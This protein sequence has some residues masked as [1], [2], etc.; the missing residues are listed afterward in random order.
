MMATLRLFVCVAVAGIASATATAA[1]PAVPAS[2]LLDAKR[3]VVL[4]DSITHDGRWL[5]DLVAWMERQG[6]AAEVIDMGLPSETVSGLSEEGHAGGKFPRPDLAERLD[7]V[8]RLT[9][10]DVVLACYGMNCG[11]YQ[12]LDEGRLAKFKAGIERLHAAVEKAG[13]KIVHL[14]PPVYGGPP[15]KPG[16]AGTVDYDA[17]LTASSEWLVS[18]RADGW[19]VID[20]HGPM[21]ALLAKRRAADPAFTFAPDAVHPD[22]A[23]H[24][25]ICRAVLAGLGAGGPIA[26]ADAPDALAQFVPEVTERLH[27]LRDAYLAAAGHLRPGVAAGL[28]VADA[29]AKAAR[30]S[31]S[32]RSRRLHLAG[33][34]VPGHQEWVSALEWPRPRVVDPGPAPAGPAAVPGDAIVLLGRDLS[35]WN[36]G[37]RWSVADGVATVGKGQ[38]TTKQG[39]GDCHLHVE[40]R[41]VAPATGKGQGRSNSGVYLMERYEIQ[42]LDSFEDGSDGPLTYPD[43]QC[44]ALYKQQPPAVNACRRPGEWQTYDILFTRPRFAADGAV[45]KPGRVSV[46]HNG[47]AIHSDTVI[48]GPTAYHMPPTYVPH[49]AALPIAL[50]DHGN[51]VQFRN[52]WVRPSEPVQPRPTLE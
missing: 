39:F 37:E 20:V 28:P 17:V 4:G 49:D 27:V 46:L 43:G 12:P 14:T 35:A 23:G 5:A 47:V 10:P 26:T 31:A 52:I 7:R 33:G 29:E 2:L 21:K 15:G 50:Q 18:K 24:W 1:E 9:R 32:I 11:I 51:P 45:E 8:L 34:Q 13:A 36:G 16:P 19:L 3:I 38:I 44:G 41:T 30:I 6:T 22:D 25:A 40:F 42:V 48:K